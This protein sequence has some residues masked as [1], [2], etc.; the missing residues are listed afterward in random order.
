[1]L[2]VWGSCYDVAH[3]QILDGYDLDSEVRVPGVEAACGFGG[4]EFWVLG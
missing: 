4:L 3:F 1:M 2:C